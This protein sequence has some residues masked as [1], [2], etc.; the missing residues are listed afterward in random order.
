MDD[1]YATFCN[2][3]H[4]TIESHV[5]ISNNMKEFST[6]H[7]IQQS[8]LIGAYKVKKLAE[9][10]NLK[11][12]AAYA[13]TFLKQGPV[14][15]ILEDLIGEKYTTDKDKAEALADH[16]KSV[17]VADYGAD[18]NLP[19]TTNKC[20]EFQIITPQTVH[21]LLRSLKPGSLT[22]DGLPQL[23]FK[24]FAKELSEPLTHMYNIFF[25]LGQ[26]PSIWKHAIINPIPKVK[27]S[28]LIPSFRPISILPTPLEV[29]EK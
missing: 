9:R 12:L 21:K 27:D 18:L 28:E 26:V 14:M 15:H 7:S 22:S 5:H 8:Q 1:I 2:I 24:A 19:P 10:G 3:I 25:I 11:Y 17:F 23:F 6:S 20:L 16:F 13:K 29:L 4:G